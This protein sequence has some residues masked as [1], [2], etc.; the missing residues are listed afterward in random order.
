[1]GFTRPSRVPPD[2]VYV[3]RMRCLVL[4]HT[5]TEGPERIGPLLEEAGLEVEVC[6]LHRGDRPPATL[7]P[8]LPLV[9][10]GGPMG[11][12][13][14]GDPAYPF[15]AVEVELLRQR[16]ALGAPVL[17]V[18]LGAQLLAHAAGAR[19]YPNTAPTGVRVYE[20]GWAP[21]DFLRDNEPTLAG[22]APRETMLH[23]H[24]DTFDLPAGAVHLASTPA[25]PHQAFRLGRSFGLQFHPELEPATIDDWLAS[26]ADYVA[27]ACGPDATPRIRAET[28]RLYPA[29]RIASDRLLRN[30]IA[31]ML[32]R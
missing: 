5:A 10:M 16:L 24:G 1:M 14:V 23:W 29:Y 30:I 3:W 27:T 17:G 13:D 22:L 31:Y 6:A 21:V 7:P 32:V 20:V 11:V 26:D 8:G 9:V 19:V 25:C 15:L 18:C 28:A 4:T 2:A 12:C